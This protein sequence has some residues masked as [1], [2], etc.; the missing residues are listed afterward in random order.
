MCGVVVGCMCG[1]TKNGTQ[2]KRQR[3]RSVLQ[4]TS[5][6]TASQQQ[7]GNEKA[8]HRS[9]PAGLKIP[10]LTDKPMTE[11]QKKD[12]AGEMGDTM[13]A[14][15]QQPSR[16]ELGSD[17]RQNLN[18][19]GG[20][21]KRLG[22]GGS[23][24]TASATRPTSGSRRARELEQRV[25]ESLNKAQNGSPA[26]SSSGKSTGKSFPGNENPGFDNDR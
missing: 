26:P 19:T 7:P 12:V 9:H 1:R 3:P 15:L 16:H 23:P 2:V 22:L 20:V 13:R 6:N 4:V 17:A 11:K 25:K 18:K 5:G 8:Q 10:K 21:F 24:H 14:G